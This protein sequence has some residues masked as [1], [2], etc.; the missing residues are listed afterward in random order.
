MALYEVRVMPKTALTGG[1]DSAECLNIE[2]ASCANIKQWIYWPQRCPCCGGDS[3]AY[4]DIRW[5]QRRAS[6][7][8][9]SETCYS[10]RVPYC[11]TCLDH[12]QVAARAPRTALIAGLLVSLALF[13][14][15]TVILSRR[16][17]SVVTLLAVL[18]A[19]V[20]GGCLEA[21]AA[22]RRYNSTKVRPMLR[23]GCSSPYA[24]VVPGGCEESVHSF[25][26]RSREYAHD[27]AQM[28]G[29]ES[30]EGWV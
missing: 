7:P 9:T 1:S 29:A 19:S 16:A 18:T 4:T 22:Y 27:F 3:D 30:V 11:Q 17:F 24:A 20:G 13:I 8:A 15:A 14:P 6:E 25:L 5:S 21:A 12:A 26:F 2:P 10:V 23:E 28:N